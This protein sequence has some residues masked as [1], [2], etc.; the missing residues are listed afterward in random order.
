MYLK[1]RRPEFA[2]SRRSPPPAAQSFA[3]S[4]LGPFP[5]GHHPLSFAQ[6]VLPC[7]VV[8]Q[9]LRPEL[10]GGVNKTDAACPQSGLITDP[11]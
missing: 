10:P 6:R 11:Q 2:I 3:S 1:L 7:C 9:I 5:K 4:P 8:Y